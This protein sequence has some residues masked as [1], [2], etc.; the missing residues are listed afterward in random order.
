MGGVI[1]YDLIVGDLKSGNPIG[2]SRLD[3]FFRKLLIGQAV[4]SC[5]LRREDAEEIVNDVLLTVI[6]DFYRRSA[7]STHLIV[8]IAAADE[9]AVSGGEQEDADP[10]LRRV[11]DRALDALQPWERTVLWCRV[12]GIP[13]SEIQEFTGRPASS[14]RGSYPRALRKFNALIRRDLE[15]GAMSVRGMSGLLRKYLPRIEDMEG[16]NEVF[17]AFHEV[18]RHR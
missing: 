9:Y 3:A 8:P 15:P 10:V 11:V 18:Q 13:Y 14:L 4:R 5:G 7:C 1:P 17:D 2:A 12:R 16:V 6:G